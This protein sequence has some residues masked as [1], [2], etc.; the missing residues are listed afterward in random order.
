MT[1]TPTPPDGPSMRD[2]L[3]VPAGRVVLAGFDSSSR[4]LAPVEHNTDLRNDVATM[5]DLQQKL[6][7]EA[8][9]GGARSIL[10]VMQGI[11]TAGK[12]GVTKHVFGSVG[13]IG[14]EYTGFKAPTKAELRHDFLWRV[15]K[16][17]PAPGV[18]GVF[19]R[20][21]YEDVL[22][23]RVHDLVP[24]SEW[25]ARYDA[26]NEFEQ[27]LV[28]GGTT[29]LKCFLDI[30]FETQR[31]RLL[32]RLDNPDK[33]WKF[34][35]SDLDERARWTDYEVAFEAML[36]RTNTDHAPWYVVP[37]DHKKYRNW[38]IGEL[39]TETLRDLAPEWPRPTLDVPAL[40]ARLAPPH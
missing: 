35:V 31:D 18:I 4:P 34:N 28:A 13:P 29:V 22:I 37:S 2:A 10:L 16:K 5:R 7:A 21:H 12:G 17:L 26:I 19:D 27:E 11:D 33:H 36:E 40:K 20:S 25:E 8:T 23:V 39:L 14:V 24:A 30:S 3:R 38:A 15:R 32:A 6:W 1:D 9:A